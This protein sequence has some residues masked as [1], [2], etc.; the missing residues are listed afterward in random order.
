MKR[1][2]IRSICIDN[3]ILNEMAL[4]VEAH[5]SYFFIFNCR[6][7]LNLYGV[8]QENKNKEGS[9]GPSILILIQIPCLPPMQ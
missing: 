6:T 8:P 9:R 4:S 3:T 1:F 2:V 7:G 5:D